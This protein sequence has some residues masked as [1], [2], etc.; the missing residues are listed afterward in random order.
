VVRIAEDPDTPIV[1]F[2]DDDA[3]AV[4]TISRAV[5]ADLGG[6]SI[7]SRRSV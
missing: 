5:G 1:S 2:L 3:A 7:S 6:H 4:V